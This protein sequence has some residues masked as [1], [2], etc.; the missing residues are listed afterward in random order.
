MCVLMLFNGHD[1][2]TYGDIA[3]ETNIPQKDL[4]RSLHSL[5]SGKTSGPV[6]TKTPS[7]EQIENDHV[8]AVNDAFTTA[9]Q[10]VKI[11]ST[12]GRNESLPT[13]SYYDM[14]WIEE[15]RKYNMDAAIVRVMKSRRMMS[16]ADLMNEV[17]NLLRARFTPS[18]D[19]LKKRIDKLLEREYI[20]RHAND[21]HIYV[22]VP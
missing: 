9:R 6:L 19:A 11:Q 20:A 4:V 17:T 21:P 8:F 3:S 16:H 22:Y 18:P 10:K 5:C 2:L 13:S 14:A 7:T 1:K 15:S 12:S